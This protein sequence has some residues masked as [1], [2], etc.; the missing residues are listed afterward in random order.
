MPGSARAHAVAEMPVDT[1]LERA[2]ELARRW[3]I[4]LILAR[5]L[6]L[7]GEVP[8]ED[9]ARDAPELL[10]QTVRA[11]RSDDDLERL[12]GGE[13]SDRA[14]STPAGRLAQLA[15]ASGARATVEAVEALRGVLWEA[16]RDELGWPNF[17][18]SSPRLI[19]DL[20]DRLSYVCATMLAAALSRGRADSLARHA[21]ASAGSREVVFEPD[22]SVPVRRPAVLVDERR[23]AP[24][25][26]RPAGLGHAPTVDPAGGSSIASEPSTRPRPRPWDTPL[27]HER[28]DRSPRPD[29]SLRSDGSPRPDGSPDSPPRTMVEVIDAAG[30]APVMRVTRRTTAPADERTWID[31]P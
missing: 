16:L 7:I 2:D 3:A 14:E 13:T 4:A 21:V 12:A 6:E 29:R 8:L 10:V 24:S 9:L 30:C 1:L 22:R 20:A 27:R 19:A 5:P 17:D 18:S 28:A 23:D 15:G 26:Q 25:P 11:L 31:E